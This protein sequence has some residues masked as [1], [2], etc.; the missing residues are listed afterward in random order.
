MKKYLSILI[1]AVSSLFADMPDKSADF[2]EQKGMIVSIFASQKEELRS[3]AGLIEQSNGDFL[4]SIGLE[5]KSALAR[6]NQGMAVFDSFHS[7]MERSKNGDELEQCNVNLQDKK[8][9]D[10]LID[11][12][13]SFYQA[14]ALQHEYARS[15]L[16]L[17]SQNSVQLNA[18]LA[19]LLSLI[20]NHSFG[21][22]NLVDTATE[23]SKRIGYP[24]FDTYFKTAIKIK[25]EIQLI[26][27]QL[28]T[29][30]E[31]SQHQNIYP[32]Y[33]TLLSHLQ[34]E[35]YKLYQMKLKLKKGD[36]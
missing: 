19:N 3:I 6:C 10:P 12:Y 30:S 24:K 29:L 16:S 2:L 26:T 1:I 5:K 21:L 27:N 35:T 23:K 25:N 13:L 33:M 15:N 8:H 7:C 28:T 32:E 4:K 18:A 9:S 11:G 31:K 22:E 14:V 36:K 17:L 34:K 20:D